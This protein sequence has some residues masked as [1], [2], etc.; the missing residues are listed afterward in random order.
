[1]FLKIEMVFF[2]VRR[3]SKIL[4]LKK[5]GGGEPLR[6]LLDKNENPFDLP[7]EIKTLILQK[8]GRASFNRYP[9]PEYAVLKERLSMYCGF[10]ADFIVPGNGGDEILWM[11]FSRYV[12]P[13]DSV[14]VFSPTFSEYY[15]LA[16]LFGANLCIVQADLNGDE[17]RFDHALF[18][19]RMA[20]LKPS[21]VLVDSP[22]NPTGQ[23][24]PVSFIGKA[25]ALCESTIVI[26]E[27]YGE[28]ARDNWL[29]SMRGKVL[30]ANVVVLKTLSKAWGLAGLRLGYAVC[31]ED[32]ASALNAARSPFNVN[33]LSGTAAEIILEHSEVML[34]RV[35][36]LCGIRDGFI[37]LVNRLQG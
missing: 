21:L 37:S 36:L 7:E 2:S 15:R 1:M 34:A 10:S 14:L 24:H 27:A 35:K 17:P 23:S 33:I 18:L 32:S 8:I 12:K 16:D 6:R 3:G 26:D 9:D 29:S 5:E 25:V 20:E 22:N 19:R 11:L 13:G 28:F 30:P 4:L 31:G